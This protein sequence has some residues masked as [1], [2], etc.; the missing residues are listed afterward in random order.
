MKKWLFLLLFGLSFLHADIVLHQREFSVTKPIKSW[1][2][3]KN[4]NLTRQNYD[5]SC[6]S[7][8]LST[9]LKYYYDLNVS[10]KDILDDV[11]KQKGFDITKKEKLEDGDTSLS[12]F[13]LAKFSQQKGFK[14]L[15]LALDLKS[16][17][18]LKAPVILYVKIRK[19]EH[20]T[21]YKNMDDRYVYLAD[22]SFGNMKIR[23]SK[24]KEMFYQR[25]DLKY[26]GKI[27]AIVPLSKER[28]KAIN[29][30][31]MKI[32]KSSNFVYETIKDRLTRLR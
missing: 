20:F 17:K 2:E 15:G 6:G 16:L 21:I 9:I 3:F 12:F 11:L 18:K 7:A 30:N 22:P 10:E 19:D 4:E 32:K 31:F 13:D 24:F 27:L 8:S 14:A 1:I 23:L 26:P 25:D 5:Y 29:K 28:V